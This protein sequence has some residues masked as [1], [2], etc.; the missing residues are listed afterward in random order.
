MNCSI[1][2]LGASITSLIIVSPFSH[3]SFASRERTSPQARVGNV[4]TRICATTTA[5]VNKKLR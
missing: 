4:V 1:H 5:Q 2:A 3:C